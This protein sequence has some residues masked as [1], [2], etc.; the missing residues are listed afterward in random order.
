[1]S[2]VEVPV[3]TGELKES[4]A[5]REMHT[6]ISDYQISSADVGRRH[7]EADQL[8]FARRNSA[9]LN[10]TGAGGQ[11]FVAHDPVLQEPLLIDDEIRFAGNRLSGL[12]LL[13][14]HSCTN[15]QESCSQEHGQPFHLGPP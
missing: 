7:S 15:G 10:T 5:I 9:L 13:K 4:I 1:M 12:R 14:K 3:T 6:R 11:L 2:K 8:M